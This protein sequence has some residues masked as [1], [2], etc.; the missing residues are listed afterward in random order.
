MKI[1]EKELEGYVPFMYGVMFKESEANESWENY[2]EYPLCCSV[3]FA[4]YIKELGNYLGLEDIVV[5]YSK[6]FNAFTFLTQIPLEK[7]EELMDKCADFNYRVYGTP[8]SKEFFSGTVT[9]YIAD[10]EELRR[11]DVTY[12]RLKTFFD[13]SMFA[14]AIRDANGDNI[15]PRVADEIQLVGYRDNAFLDVDD[16]NM[17]ENGEL[18]IIGNYVIKEKKGDCFYLD[19]DDVVSTISEEDLRDIDEY[20]ENCVGNVT[21]YTGEYDSTISFTG[22]EVIIVTDASVVRRSKGVEGNAKRDCFFD[23][24]DDGESNG[25][26]RYTEHFKQISNGFRL[27][28]YSEEFDIFEVFDLPINWSIADGITK[29]IRDSVRVFDSSSFGEEEKDYTEIC[30]ILSSRNLSGEKGNEYIKK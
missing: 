14:E 10:A 21:T 17:N 26:N 9:T 29:P 8:F 24:Y 4:N 20:L 16:A 13:E 25:P 11:E 5:K 18:N 1:C 3:R 23:L 15:M 28:H 30:N 19:C 22:D 12:D 7:R 6:K 27:L 2:K